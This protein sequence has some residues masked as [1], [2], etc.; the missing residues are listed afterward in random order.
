MFFVNAGLC[1][2]GSVLPGAGEIGTEFD[3]EA[4]GV[5]RRPFEAD[6]AIRQALNACEERGGGI[7]PSVADLTGRG[8]PAGEDLVG[9]IGPRQ[10]VTLAIGGFRPGGAIFVANE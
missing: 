8:L 7:G 2:S 9:G 10:A 5:G 4:F 6:P 1:G 3:A